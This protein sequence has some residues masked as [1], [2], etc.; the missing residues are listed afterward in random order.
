MFRDVCIVCFQHRY[1]IVDGSN[2]D[3]LWSTKKLGPL[4]LLDL[5]SGDELGTKLGLEAVE[6]NGNAVFDHLRYSAVKDTS[7]DQVIS[8]PIVLEPVL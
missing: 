8:C 2:P 6:V 3:I 5:L 7:K 4:G 1:D